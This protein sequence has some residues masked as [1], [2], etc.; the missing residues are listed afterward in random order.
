MLW[1]DTE[2]T[3]EDIEKEFGKDVANLVDGVTKLGKI[4]YQ[5]KE[6][7]QSENLRKT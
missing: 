5:S 2:Y 1:M 6:E 7:T 4:K 3:Y